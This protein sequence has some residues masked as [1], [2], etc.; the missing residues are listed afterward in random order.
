MDT[1]YQKD[2]IAIELGQLPNIE[3]FVRLTD[4]NCEQVGSVSIL[5]HLIKQFYSNKKG[6]TVIIT[7]V[8]TLTGEEDFFHVVKESIEAV[9]VRII[10][11][12]A[13]YRKEQK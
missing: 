12:S 13:M 4:V 2:Q 3:R 8:Q 1:L 11:A 9:E 7:K 5:P 6:N 10:S